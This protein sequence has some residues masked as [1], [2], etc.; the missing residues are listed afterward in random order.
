MTYEE[1]CARL[2]DLVLDQ[3][4][5]ARGVKR[6]DDYK[7]ISP[8]ARS[9]M[10]VSMFYSALKEPDIGTLN[11]V[12]HQLIFTY[13]MYPIVYT[14]DIFW[15][16]VTDFVHRV[17]SLSRDVTDDAAI[18]AA[19][20]MD[21]RNIEMLSID[22]FS[23]LDDYIKTHSVG[24]IVAYGKYLYQCTRD[25]NVIQLVAWRLSQEKGEYVVRW[26]N[27]CQSDVYKLVRDKQS[28]S[29]VQSREI[30]RR[31]LPEVT[32][33]VRDRVYEIQDTSGSDMAL[34]FLLD[35]YEALYY[36]LPKGD[37]EL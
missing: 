16:N 13:Y 21:G 33:P 36:S 24:E 4:Q 9:E 19:I 27:W 25:E 17:M 7:P 26:T 32:S 30:F 6:R 28:V 35:E 2:E 8:F 20:L 12:V 3:I 23:A 37:T 29:L 18:A 1:V 5:Y 22:S 15:G 31:A 10:L 14:S 11:S 34:Q